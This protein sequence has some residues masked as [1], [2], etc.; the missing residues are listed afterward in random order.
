M[1][2]KQTKYLRGLAGKSNTQIIGITREE[3]RDWRRR[4]YQ[5]YYIRKFPRTKGCTFSD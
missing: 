4:N 2:S 5:R 1:E 3:N